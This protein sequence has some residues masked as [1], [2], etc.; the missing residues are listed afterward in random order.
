MK[1]RLS[2]YNKDS[3]HEVIYY[4]GFESEEVMLLAE[5][6]V[7]SKLDQYREKTNRDR[8]ILPIGKDIKLFTSV[9]DKTVVFF[10]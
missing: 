1:D 7:L 2:V 10:S 6:I 5:K 4:K 9:I 8:F 3:D